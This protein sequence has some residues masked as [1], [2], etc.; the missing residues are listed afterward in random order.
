MV[1]SFWYGLTDRFIVKKRP[2]LNIFQ[3]RLILLLLPEEKLVADNG[4]QFSQ[5]VTAL[6]K[7]KKKSILNCV[8]ET[9]LATRD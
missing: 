3:G 5:Y 8:H 2:D 1:V 4:Y 7:K 6:E 9:R